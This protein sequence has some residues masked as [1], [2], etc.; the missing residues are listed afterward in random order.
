[1]SESKTTYDIAIEEF[2]KVK[3]S[4]QKIYPNTIA[5]LGGF[6][7]TNFNKKTG[8]WS[9]LRDKILTRNLALDIAEESRNKDL[10]IDNLN[11]EVAR[12]KKKLKH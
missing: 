10:L 4:K 11:K 8:K 1:M 5:K 6:S 12:L 2:E 9:E 7:H 3:D